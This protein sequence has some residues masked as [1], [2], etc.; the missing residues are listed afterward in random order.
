M[1]IYL[2]VV[3]L[4]QVIR[5]P[6]IIQCKETEECGFPGSL[7][8]YQTEHFICL[9]TRTVDSA[10][11]FHQE[12]FHNLIDKIRSIS[13]HIPLQYITDSLLSVPFQLFQILTDWVVCPAV[14]FYAECLIHTFFTCELV[15]PF[16]EI[17]KI[18]PAIIVQFADFL[19]PP[20]FFHNI[21]PACQLVVLHA[22]THKRII[23]QHDHIISYRC[24]R[25][26]LLCIF[27]HLFHFI[28]FTFICHPEHFFHG[29]FLFFCS[30]LLYLLFRI[31]QSSPSPSIFL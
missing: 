11:R 29:I 19:I 7:L 3:Q 22:L 16:K 31:A 30:N 9:T 2:T 4:F 17:I 18:S 28:D 13:S 25:S 24:F 1:L 20:E 23:S 6:V 15:I 8:T 26:S 21:N 10:Q 5:K 14:G 27:Q 12:M